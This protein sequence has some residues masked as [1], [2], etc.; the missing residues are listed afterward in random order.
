MNPEETLFESEIDQPVSEDEKGRGPIPIL[1][2]T[3][4][5]QLEVEQAVRAV[6]GDGM[7][8]KPVDPARL[9]LM[10]EEAAAA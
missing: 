10:V 8:T 6:G 9:V 4:D 3:A 1:A 7:I 5:G 2:L